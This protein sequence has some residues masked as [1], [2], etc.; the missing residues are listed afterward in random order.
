[1]EP[2]FLSKCKLQLSVIAPDYLFKKNRS[3]ERIICKFKI[4]DFKIFN[5]F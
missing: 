5:N 3:P 2:K 4:R 1:M